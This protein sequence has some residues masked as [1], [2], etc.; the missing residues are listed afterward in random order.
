MH[1][2]NRCCVNALACVLVLFARAVSAD[3]AS[4]PDCKNVTS[5]SEVPEKIMR[6]LSSTPNISRF[7]KCIT[8]EGVVSY[9]INTGLSEGSSHLCSFKKFIFTGDVVDQNGEPDEHAFVLYAKDARGCAASDEGSFVPTD[10]LSECEYLLISN[11][12]N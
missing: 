12:F 8:R 3:I 5:Y 9:T 6:I 11:V 4:A 1:T 10:N 2:V 7:E